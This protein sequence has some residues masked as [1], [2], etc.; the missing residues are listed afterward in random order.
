MT[1]LPHI[2]RHLLATGWGRGG[3]FHVAHRHGGGRLPGEYGYKIDSAEALFAFCL[4]HLTE[5]AAETCEAH[6]A[7]VKLGK[8]RFVWV[9][10]D[11]VQ[12][13]VGKQQHTGAAGQRSHM[14][15]FTSG[16]MLV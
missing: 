2:T 13:P 8:R 10:L 11:K 12:H 6:A 16:G 4:L 14:C 1:H 7:R 3:D 5:A 9:P 15:F